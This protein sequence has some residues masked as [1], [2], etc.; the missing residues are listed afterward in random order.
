MIFEEVCVKKYLSFSLIIIFFTLVSIACQLSA[1]TDTD[2]EITEIALAIQQTRIAMQQTADSQAGQQET[3]AEPIDQPTY[4]PE[5]TYTPR[6]EVTPE[7]QAEPGIEPSATVNQTATPDKLFQK[8]TVDRTTFYCVSANGPTQLTITVQ[9]S[10]IGRGAALFWR[11]QEKSSGKK[12]DWVIVDMRRE[13]GSTRSFTFDANSSAGT[14]NFFYPPLMGESW[15]Q[16][17]IVSN[18]GME[19]TEVFSDVTFFP[20]AN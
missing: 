11:L 13:T 4:T 5:P 9:M 19:R 17:Q 15:F 14:N 3:N 6:S 16:Y 10:D 1:N 2:I 8:V 7:G 18:D 20:C 12:L